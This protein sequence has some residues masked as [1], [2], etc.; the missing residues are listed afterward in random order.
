MLYLPTK[1]LQQLIYYW[2][3]QNLVKKKLQLN[4]SC[5]RTQ[6]RSYVLTRL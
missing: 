5:Q 1:L 2:S 3:S 6:S 4:F